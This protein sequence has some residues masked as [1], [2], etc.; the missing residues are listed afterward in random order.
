MDLS[1]IGFV[2]REMFE[3]VI[4]FVVVVE[5]GVGFLLALEVVLDLVNWKWFLNVGVQLVLDEDLKF[6]NVVR[7]FSV[8]DG[9]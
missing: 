9:R 7:W 2:V 1:L 6:Q 8:E 3:F 4:V 5:D